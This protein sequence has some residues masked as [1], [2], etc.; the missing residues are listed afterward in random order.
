METQKLLIGLMA[1]LVLMAGVQAYQL[2]AVSRV[3]SEG[4]IVSASSSSA[5]ASSQSSSQSVLG[6]IPTQVGGC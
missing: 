1:L 6:S 5:G 4:G 3:I 2:T